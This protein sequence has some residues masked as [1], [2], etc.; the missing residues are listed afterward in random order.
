MGLPLLTDVSL[1]NNLSDPAI[2]PALR[3]M[4]IMQALGMLIFPSLYCLYLNQGDLR[5]LDVLKRPK[6]QPVLLSI[7]V[8][9]VA[10]PFINFIADWNAHLELPGAFGQWASDKEAHLTE[11]TSGFLKMPHMGWLALNLFM[12]ALL[13]ALGEELL[14]RGVLQPAVSRWSGN[15]HVGVWVAAFLFSAI[16]MQ[17][18]GFVPRLLM[19][20]LLGYLLLWSGNLWY[21][22]VAH[23][24]NN[25]MAIVFSYMEQQ[26]MAA[27]TQTGDFGIADPLLASFSLVFV[28]MLLY[29]FRMF[30]ATPQTN[31]TQ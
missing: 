10:L 14:F 6:R 12:V 4:Q 31:D 18:F 11:L 19:G 26:G 1:V 23:F 15:I 16:H 9:M 2:F 27:G 3:L 17:F 30:F 25:A 8:F 13:P 21:P 20:A 24:C 7:A 5:K 28:L 22:I 29:L